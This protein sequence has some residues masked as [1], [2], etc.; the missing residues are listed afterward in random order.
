MALKLY[1][2]ADIQAI[3]N[4]IREKTETTDT[5]LVS[6]MAQAIADISTGRPVAFGTVKPSTSSYLQIDHNLGVKPTWFVAVSTASGRYYVHAAA[7]NAAYSSSVTI[8]YY[9]S[10]TTK[11]IG[12][13]KGSTS[14][15]YIDANTITV[16]YYSGSYYWYTSDTV[17]WACGA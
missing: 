15:A 13:Q 16:P 4:S 8:Q 12:T 14:T 1:D 11:N 9:Y 5:F 3:A 10:A 6:Q 7:Y 2:E 17:I